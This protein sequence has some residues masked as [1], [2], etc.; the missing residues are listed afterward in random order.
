MK[1]LACFAWYPPPY[2]NSRIASKHAG[3]SDGNCAICEFDLYFQSL[4]GKIL[5]SKDLRAVFPQN[6]IPPGFVM[7]D[8]F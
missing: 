1:E 5:S 4:T 2:P 6:D 8:Y 3:G 7:M